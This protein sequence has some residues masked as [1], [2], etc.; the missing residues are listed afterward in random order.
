M[1]RSISGIAIGCLSMLL[2]A[3]T[4]AST[5][6]AADLPATNFPVRPVRLIVAVPPGNGADT[7]ARSIAQALTERWGRSVIVDNRSGAGGAI[8]MD[9]TARATP[10]GHTLLFASI[11]LVAT[12]TMLKKV[13]YDTLKT[14]TP[15]AQ[16]TV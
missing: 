14:F 7:V 16:M 6:F 8:A 12:A 15:V 5:A 9:L 3:C 4:C 11:G 13:D 1:N 10:D 2:L